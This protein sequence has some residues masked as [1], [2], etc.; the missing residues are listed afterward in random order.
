MRLKG[1]RWRGG[2]NEPRFLHTL[3]AF[4]GLRTQLQPHFLRES[5]GVLKNVN[6]R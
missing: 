4:A 3:A 5:A 2:D 6:E 1:S